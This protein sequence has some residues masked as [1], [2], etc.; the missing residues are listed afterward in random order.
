MF[1]RSNALQSRDYEELLMKGFSTPFE[2]FKIKSTFSILHSFLLFV[3][4]LTLELCIHGRIY[5][6]LAA[7]YRCLAKK[8]AKRWHCSIYRLL[9]SNL[10]IP[11]SPRK[12]HNYKFVGSNFS[13]NFVIL[14]NFSHSYFLSRRV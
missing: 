1:V 5:N 4:L 10:S 11:T 8:S 12:K 13:Y 3:Q 2:K 7:R 6:L 9:C 14:V